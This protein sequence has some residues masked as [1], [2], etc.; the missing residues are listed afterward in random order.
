MLWA[1]ALL[2]LVP[3]AFVW[4]SDE[5]EDD[6]D[7]AQ[8]AENVAEDVD[9][10]DG[11]A[12]PEDMSSLLDFAFP[13]APTGT[14]IDGADES[15]VLLPNDPDEPDVAGPSGSPF[16][17]VIGANDPDTADEAGPEGSPDD[18]V[19]DPNGEED[20]VVGDNSGDT[21]I[22]TL[23]DSG[24][25]FVLTDDP[26]S[27]GVA[28]TLVD[29]PDGPTFDTG[30]TLHIVEGGDGDDTIA[31][32]DDAAVIAGGAGNDAIY[33]GDGSAVLDGGD[34]N[35]LLIAGEDDGSTYVMT[36]GA[37]TDGFGLHFD[38]ATGAPA[39]SITDYVGGEDVIMIEVDNVTAARGPID[40]TIEPTQDGLS[41]EVLVNGV[42]VAYVD[43]VTDLQASDV[44]VTVA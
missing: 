10:S 5:T 6:T 1:L 25:T 40:V 8:G 35:D 20:N 33:G 2:G 3:A 26:Q 15:D 19:L 28:A 16:D 9:G 42:S 14:L 17:V 34:G 37:G 23:S 24:E 21:Q 43:G 18:V 22:H 44:I 29:G 30:G 27:G 39:V 13:D 7:T 4:T 12:A 38:S 31:A 36:G 41:S 32:G 11:D